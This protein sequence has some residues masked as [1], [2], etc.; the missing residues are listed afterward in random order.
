MKSRAVE[1]YNDLTARLGNERT[2]NDFAGYS[3]MFKS[4]KRGKDNLSSIYSPDPELLGKIKQ[5][6]RVQN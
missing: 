3:Y 6:Q 4:A 2:S 5:D 1:M